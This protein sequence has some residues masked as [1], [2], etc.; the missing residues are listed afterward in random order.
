MNTPFGKSLRTDTVNQT[1]PTIKPTIIHIN[2]A[3]IPGHSYPNHFLIGS[4]NSDVDVP[5]YGHNIDNRTG[6]NPQ[7]LI[8]TTI[9]ES[10]RA[11]NYDIFDFF[12]ETS[13]ISYMRLLWYGKLKAK[14]K[15]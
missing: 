1:N 6:V 7:G 8:V 14:V 5:I 13:N 10:N 12:R 2:Q 11:N 3:T 4:L 9:P 15:T